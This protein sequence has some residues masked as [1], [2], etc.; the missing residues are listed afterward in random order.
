MALLWTKY[1]PLSPISK[2]WSCRNY[3]HLWISTCNCFFDFWTHLA[4]YLILRDLD[5][6]LEIYRNTSSLTLLLPIEPMSSLCPCHF[7]I[8]L[9]QLIFYYSCLILYWT[10]VTIFRYILLGSLDNFTTL[11]IISVALCWHTW[12]PLRIWIL[13]PSKPI[14]E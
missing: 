11:I 8:I 12:K 14:S 6:L 4:S 10:S 5:L 3:T 2:I 7:E 1:F 13:V 9:A